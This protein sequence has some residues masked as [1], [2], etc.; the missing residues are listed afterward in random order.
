MKLRL[1]DNEAISFP[2]A[3]VVP[4]NADFDGDTVSIQ[5]VPEESAEDTYQKMSP[6][7]VTVYKKNN[8]VIPQINHETLDLGAYRN[9]G[10]I[11]LNCWKRK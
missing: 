11:S 8:E 9:I 10:F 6:R 3:Q 1:T 5:L 2:I 4:L 7:Y